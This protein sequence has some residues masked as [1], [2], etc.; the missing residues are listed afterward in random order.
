MH[1]EG[2][3]H[4]HEERA[5]EQPDAHLLGWLLAAAVVSA[6]GELTIP[7]NPNTNFDFSMEF[8]HANNTWRLTARAEEESAVVTI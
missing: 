2:I 8:D 3:F 5:Q 7:E 4:E 1:E 6:G